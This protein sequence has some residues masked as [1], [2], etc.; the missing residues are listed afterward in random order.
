MM[1]DQYVAEQLWNEREQEWERKVRR[2][3]FIEY[4]M[5]K[6]SFFRKLFSSRRVGSYGSSKKDNSS[7]CS[8]AE[9]MEE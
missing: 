6:V 5:P 9:T 1:I 7:S 4:G 8:R 2:G 3:D